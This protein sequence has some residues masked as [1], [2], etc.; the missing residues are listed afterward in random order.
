MHIMCVRGH[1]H[2]CMACL[3]FTYTAFIYISFPRIYLLGQGKFAL[4]WTSSWSAKNSATIVKKRLDL[5][6]ELSFKRKLRFSREEN[7]TW[8]TALN[9]VTSDSL[10]MMNRPLCTKL[11][12]QTL[13]PLKAG[14]VYYYIS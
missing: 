13:K 10:N 8:K 3:K 2:V 14:T 7:E 11:T 12:Y 5:G 4:S 6:K 9:Q 1:T